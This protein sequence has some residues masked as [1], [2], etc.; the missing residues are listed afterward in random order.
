MPIVMY[1]SD[2]RILTG[3][4]KFEECSINRVRGWVNTIHEL[5]VTTQDPIAASFSPILNIDSGWKNKYSSNIEIEMKN[6][7]IYRMGGWESK[8]SSHLVI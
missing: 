8:H 2:F 5:R 1:A 7:N 4:Q 6:E 3:T